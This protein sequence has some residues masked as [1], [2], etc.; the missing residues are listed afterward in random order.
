MVELVKQ[1]AASDEDGKVEDNLERCG[2]DPAA[3]YSSLV[4]FSTLALLAVCS[5]FIARSRIFSTLKVFVAVPQWR[6]F[7]ARLM[8]LPSGSHAV[9]LAIFSI[10]E[11]VSSA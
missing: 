8:S 10:K 4:S 7:A 2:K 6:S 5:R 3:G 9:F 11:E 1:I